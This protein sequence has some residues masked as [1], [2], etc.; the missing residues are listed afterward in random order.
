MTMEPSRTRVPNPPARPLLIYDGHCG[1]CLWWLT[2]WRR[3]V[4]DR[5]DY[6]PSQEVASRFPALPRQRFSRSIQLVE[7]DGT[8]YEGAEAAFRV[9]SRAPRGGRPLWAYEHLPG[10]R[11]ATER[12]YQFVSR[13]RT[14]LYKLTLWTFG[15]DPLASPRARK[16]ALP[17]LGAALVLWIALL[18]R[19]RSR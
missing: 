6:A 11:L 4:G 5:I 1:F 14:G 3:R 17:V 12:G 19:R 9:L 7:P 15:R 2:R 16:L 18:T 8:V 13:H 10:V